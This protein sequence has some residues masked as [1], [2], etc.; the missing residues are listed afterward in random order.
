MIKI[1]TTS[2]GTVRTLVRDLVGRTVR[3]DRVLRNEYTEVPAGTEFEVV[4]FFRG[5]DLRGPK[6][7]TCG[8]AVFFRKIPYRDVELVPRKETGE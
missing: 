6:C 1:R 3:V 5:L 7:S 4:G 8:V 2:G